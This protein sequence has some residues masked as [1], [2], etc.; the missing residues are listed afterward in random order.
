MDRPMKGWGS[1]LKLAFSP[2]PRTVAT[3]RLHQW[4]LSK[5]TKT[6]SQS[7]HF[8]LDVVDQ[9]L[10]SRPTSQTR[11][12]INLLLPMTSPLQPL[13]LA[14]WPLPPTVVTLPLPH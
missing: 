4:S 5:T 12:L 14:F 1:Q 6:A 8:D 7:L 11:K 3:L 10:R 13:E 2:L 9:D